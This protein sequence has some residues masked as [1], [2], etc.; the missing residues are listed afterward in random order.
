SADVGSALQDDEE[1]RSRIALSDDGLAR[2]VDPDRGLLGDGFQFLRT[3]NREK[4]DPAQGSEDPLSLG[5]HHLVFVLPLRDVDRALG[6]RDLDAVALER[7]PDVRQDLPFDDP[8][9]PVVLAPERQ[10]ILDAGI[11]VG[12][13]EGLRRRLMEHPGNCL[14]R[15]DQ[16]GLHLQTR[17]RIAGIY[18]YGPRVARGRLALSHDYL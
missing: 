15:L 14:R 18:Q 5:R 1:L 13:Y 10:A 12:R 16:H 4:V 8:R 9:V 7:V 3:E 17:R 6:E 2:Q 11:L